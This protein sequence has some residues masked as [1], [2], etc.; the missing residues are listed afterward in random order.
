MLLI[1]FSTLIIFVVG[2][3]NIM[4][5]SR[6]YLSLIDFGFAKKIPFLH[7]DPNGVK[8]IKMKSFTLCGTPGTYTL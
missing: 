7:V 6:G 8:L 4:I 1:Y 3:E 2:V 5:N